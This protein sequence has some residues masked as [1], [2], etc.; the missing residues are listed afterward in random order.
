[1]LPDLERLIRLQQLETAVGEA[2][3]AIEAFPA[4]REELA[5]RL[6]GH[7]SRLE[8]AERRL[9]EHRQARR[10]LEKD[11]AAV[12]GRLTRFKEQLMAVKT[13]KEYHAVQSEIA[14]ADAEVRRL[15][16]LILEGMLEADELSADIETTRQ[17]DRKS[18]V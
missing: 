13:N 16:D 5:A 2:R 10:V 14:G 17:A 8:A 9:A 11:V 1:M 6:A 15:E 4:Q 12:Q 18:V 3:Q 7:T